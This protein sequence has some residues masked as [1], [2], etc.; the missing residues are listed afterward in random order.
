M[1]TWS[2]KS[3]H[4]LLLV[5]IPAVFILWAEQC[6]LKVDEQAAQASA[7][8]TTVFSLFFSKY[9]YKSDTSCW[10]KQSQLSQG[11]QRSPVFHYVP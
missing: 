7:S 2:G 11:Y 3:T 10:C 9:L 4:V 5:Y 8:F 6:E 1:Y